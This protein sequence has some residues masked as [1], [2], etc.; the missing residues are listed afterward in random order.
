MHV[1]IKH[2]ALNSHKNKVAN[3]EQVFNL[4][5]LIYKK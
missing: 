5:I 3:F 2:N 1:E 4:T